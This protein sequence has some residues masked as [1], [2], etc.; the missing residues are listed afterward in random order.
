MSLVHT[1]EVNVLQKTP[2]FSSFNVTFFVLADILL[3][4]GDELKLNLPKFARPLILFFLIRLFRTSRF[5]RNYSIFLY[6]RLQL[7]HPKL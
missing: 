3:P 7:F 6:L 5:K 2:A 1:T 4:K